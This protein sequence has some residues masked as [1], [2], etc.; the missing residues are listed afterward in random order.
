MRNDVGCKK[1]DVDSR[2]KNADRGDRT[3]WCLVE[4]CDISDDSGNPAV[5]LEPGNTIQYSEGSIWYYTNRD[6][7]KRC[8]SHPGGQKKWQKKC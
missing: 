4:I 7:Q 8:I 3:P 5:L 1:E 2:S 6:C